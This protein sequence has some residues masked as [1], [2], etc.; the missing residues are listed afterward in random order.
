[1][2]GPLLLT[3]GMGIGPEVSLAALAARPELWSRVVLVGRASALRAVGSPLP[4]VPVSAPRPVDAGIALFDPGDEGEPAEV[5]AIRLSALACLAG[6]A[7]ALITGPI[8]KARLAGRGFAWL[9]H[10]D[11]LG[12]LCGARPV[13]AFVGGRFGVAL[14]T[15]HLPLAAVPAA[16]R[17]EAVEHTARVAALAWRDQLGMAAPRIG[18]CG[19]NP[20]AGEE[21]LLGREEIEQIAPACE[22]LRAEGWALRGP[23]SAETA[24]M[25]AMAGRLDLVVA[26]YHDQGLAPLK[27]VD[28]GRTVNWT[29][30]LP[31]LRTSVDHG[32]ADHLVGT[33]QADP[34]SMGAALDLAARLRPPVIP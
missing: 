20:H 5:A 29:L 19:L 1:M 30:G 24:M 4:L 21:G 33:G 13:M 32:T 11:M 27:A 26:M 10:T 22:R 18:V 14:V 12:E 23:I 2:T 6:R 28:F 25:E 16:I 34:A 17:A 31:I 3:P 8:H 7:H 15:V 9:G